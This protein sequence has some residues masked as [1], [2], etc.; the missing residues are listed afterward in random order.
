MWTCYREC[1]DYYGNSEFCEPWE[2]EIFEEQRQGGLFRQ[3]KD[4]Y[5]KKLILSLPYLDETI[6]FHTKEKAREKFIQELE[7]KL[8]C[9]LKEVEELKEKINNEI[10][11]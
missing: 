6:L 4:R 11:S 2:G 5:G 9:L 10:N 1:D 8:K 3:L 7:F